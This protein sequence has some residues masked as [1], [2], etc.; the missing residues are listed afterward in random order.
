M[1]KKREELVQS[2]IE[3]MVSVIKG[4]HAR[5]GFPFGECKLSR[6]QVMILFFISKKKEGASVKDVA[7]FL[8]VTP[9]AITQFIDTLVKKKLVVRE[10]DLHDRRILRIKLTASA[11]KKF[12]A[13]KKS[14]YKSVTPAFNTLSEKEMQRF[15]SFLNKIAIS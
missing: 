5:H 14:Y 6:P 15:V 4:M 13:F 9:G 1:N 2:L 11:K 3:K 12:A 7:Q 8:N 10:E